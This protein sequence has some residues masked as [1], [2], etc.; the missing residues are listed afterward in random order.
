MC[1][2]HQHVQVQDDVTKNRRVSCLFPLHVE[3]PM[4][5]E[6]TRETDR[7]II[8]W[9]GKLREII[10]LIEWYHYAKNKS[11]SDL[12]YETRKTSIK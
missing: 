6:V 4:E 12:S 1:W 8:Y 10:I 3:G 9:E 7:Y 2:V 5:N 11:S